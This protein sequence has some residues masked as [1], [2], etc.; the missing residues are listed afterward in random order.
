MDVKAMPKGEPSVALPLCLNC[1]EYIRATDV[2]CPHCTQDPTKPGGRYKEDG[3]Y[4]RDAL[5]NLLDAMERA[6]TK[7]T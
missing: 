4:A 3:F 1:A 2:P 6:A 5:E 7:Q